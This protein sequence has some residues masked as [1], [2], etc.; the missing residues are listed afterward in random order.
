MEIDGPDFPNELRTISTALAEF[1]GPAQVEQQGPHGPLKVDLGIVPSPRVEEERMPTRPDRRATIEA[2]LNACRVIPSP[3]ERVA[4]RWAAEGNQDT[5]ALREPGPVFDSPGWQLA[6]PDRDALGLAA[7]LPLRAVE[8]DLE[9]VGPKHEPHLEFVAP[10][11]VIALIGDELAVAIEFG[12]PAERKRAAQHRRS[13]TRRPR[14]RPVAEEHPASDSAGP[15]DAAR[16]HL[17]IASDDMS[18]P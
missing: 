4:R 6:R 16:E 7:H 14:K 12:L 13:E 11:R 18:A 5:I 1:L 15:S 9:L 8:H 17:D 2:V 3:V 10:L